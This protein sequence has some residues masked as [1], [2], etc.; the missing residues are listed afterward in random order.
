MNSGMIAPDI[1]SVAI[2]GM[3]ARF[4]GAPDIETFWENLRNGIESVKIFSDEELE[5][6][7]IDKATLADPNY[8]KVAATIPDIE[9]FDAEYFNYSPKEA[10]FI[11]PQQRIFLEC[12]LHALES[13]G[14]DPAKYAGSIGAFAGAAIDIYQGPLAAAHDFE[15]RSSGVLRAL[16]VHGNDKDHLTTRTSYKLHLRGPSM[17]IQTACSTSLVAVHIACQSVLSGECDMALA[18]GVSVLRGL[19]KRGY[20]FVDGGI[21]SPDGH[22]RPFDA[23]ARGTVF[24]DGVGIVV[25]K[26]LAQALLD[27]DKIHAVIRGSAV[28]NDGSD[29]VGYTAPSV[30]GQSAVIAEALAVAG[31]D[32]NSISYI[33]THGTGTEQGDPI[34]IAALGEMFRTRDRKAQSCAIG[35]AKGNIG[36]LNTAAGIAGLIKTVLA[37]E[38]GYLPPSINFK[39]PNPKID[40]R[41]T[42][43]YVNDRL[44]AWPAH[45]GPLRA[46]V[47]SFGIGGTNA[48]VVVEEAPAVHA[49]PSQRAWHVLVLSGRTPNALET[50]TDNLYRHLR[51]SSDMNAADVA[52]TLSAGRK[53]HRYGRAI[54]CRNIAEAENLLETHN[55][56]GVFSGERGAH[57]NPVVF[58]FPGQGSQR[59]NMGRELYQ[60]EP[61]FRR[62]IDQCN[63][64]LGSSMRMDLRRI[65]L[66]HAG[67][68]MDAARRLTETE[69]AQPA[70][71]AV[72]YAMAKL[73]MSWG[74]MPHAMIGHSIGELVAACLAGVF[75]LE[76]ALVAVGTRG[77]LMQEMPRGAMLGVGASID[78]VKPF[79]E[80]DLSIAAINARDSCVVSGS[81]DA[82]AEF[83]LAL[84][85]GKIPAFR[86]RTSHAF[87]SA[88]MA[89]AVEP[90]VTNVKAL[91]LRSPSIP[92]VSN[93]TG[94]WITPEQATDPSY[95]GRHLLHTVNFAEGLRTLAE[96]QSLFLEVG[97]GRTLTSLVLSHAFDPAKI[98]ALASLPFS[99][100][101]KSEME[102]ILQAAAQLWLAGV[103]VEWSAFYQG[104]QRKRVPLPPYPFERKRYWIEPKHMAEKARMPEIAA[105]LNEAFYVRSWRRV[106]HEPPAWNAEDLAKTNWLIFA[107]EDRLSQELIEVLRP[108]CKNLAVV[109]AED[110]FV[111]CGD[112]TFALSPARAE[113]FEALI[114]ALKRAGRSPDR[115]MFL[116]SVLPRRSDLRRVEAAVDRAFCGLLHLLQAVERAD[117]KQRIELAVVVSNTEDV[118]GGESVRPLGTIARGPCYVGNLECE[119][120]RCRY[121]DISIE[122][123]TAAGRPRIIDRLIRDLAGPA[124]DVV[125]AYRR[126]RV[127]VAKPE[128]VKLDPIEPKSILRQGGVYLITGGMGAIGLELALALTEAANTKLVLVGRNR[129]PDR[130]QWDRYVAGADE[131]DRAANIIRSVREIEKRGSEVMIAAA[132]VTNLSA[133]RAVVKLVHAR[134]GKINGVIHAA[135]ISSSQPIAFTARAACL[136]ILNPKLQGTLVLDR[137]FGG[138]DIDFLVLFS[139]ISALDGYLGHVGYSAA[140]SFLDS[141]AWSKSSTRLCRTIS[142]N[143]DLWSETGMITNARLPKQLRSAHAAELKHGIKTADGIDAFFRILRSGLPQVV[144]STRRHSAR[145]GDLAGGPQA[146][147]Q[148]MRMSDATVGA[149]KRADPRHSRPDMRE[150]FVAPHT[151][152]QHVIAKMWAE[153]LNLR[154]VGINDDFFE[155]G[156]HSL[157]ALQL[158]S[159]LRNHFQVE[160]T[161]ADFFSASTVAAVSMVVEERLVAEIGQI[162][163]AVAAER[164]ED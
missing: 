132:D 153:S 142:I 161:A 1:Q 126:D 55:P 52:Y 26:R 65:L 3:A 113:Q 35:S 131:A 46:G 117:I 7:G 33:E 118:L 41:N 99:S 73:W 86:L 21:L 32:P 61:V 96:R 67:N 76:D 164:A 119:S 79:L 50:A 69:F 82:I 71:F 116:W 162:S 89:P 124:P 152:L 155:L 128:Q 157:L 63:E 64:L 90:F 146:L 163:E 22:C 98:S 62:E 24:G 38:H 15:I 37:L 108:R 44:T 59:L 48:H 40:F 158:L 120:V 14:Y 127:W 110:D 2:I 80:N 107:G 81:L 28:N 70:I 144:V 159:R 57:D 75:T 114:S 83:E 53:I 101:R 151:N 72:C 125:V 5:A 136:N 133:M 51:R 93:V 20:Y 8:V 43:F 91:K 94:K 87:H 122:E 134:F 156:G 54:V 47:S 39:E 23:A 13:A 138:L 130:E 115:I 19:H 106:V 60:H 139:S 25:L 9:L 85:K 104:E 78:D 150:D 45:D 97:V 95:W 16:F 30:N 135:G 11:D 145:G 143:W 103:A 137:I 129:L 31:I 17:A 109:R 66:S 4:P 42:P 74:V 29:K 112:L 92:F 100:D 27:N 141:Y 18:G 111:G 77:R 36:H 102:S 160:L 34:E 147:Q 49:I 121:I 154:S 123:C 58:M 68:E 6:D 12:A 56:Q 149:P 140:N 10:E 84:R 148:V 105:K 88:M